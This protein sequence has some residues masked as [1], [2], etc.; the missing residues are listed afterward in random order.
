MIDLLTDLEAQDETHAVIITDNGAPVPLL[1]MLQQILS[2]HWLSIFD[3]RDASPV[4]A[5]NAC[6]ETVWQQYGPFCNI[7]LLSENISI[8]PRFIS[9]LAQGLRRHQDIA[10]V[11]PTDDSERQQAFGI[12]R[13]E[14]GEMQSGQIRNLINSA[15]MIRGQMASTYRFAEE[16]TEAGLQKEL[17]GREQCAAVTFDTHFSQSDD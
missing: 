13:I 2:S 12:K 14:D 5:W 3:Q 10:A 7:A 15:L 4:G 6:L 17:S 9:A 16:D 8:G 1:M 11:G